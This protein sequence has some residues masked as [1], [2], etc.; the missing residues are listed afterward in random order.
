MS[1]D[2]SHLLKLAG[3]KQLNESTIEELHGSMSDRDYMSRSMKLAT[4]GST[5]PQPKKTLP[6]SPASQ[7]NWSPEDR[8]VTNESVLSNRDFHQRMH[9]IHS[10][11]HASNLA[12]A[13]YHAGRATLMSDLPQD[14]IDHHNNWA[15]HHTATA[16]YHADR[17]NFHNEKLA[18][19]I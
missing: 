18:S 8:D 15:D 12:S 1:D 5:G 11:E 6:A 16:Q 13:G 7:S 2:L 14:I 4:P 17:K 19:D 10:R 3:V 9:N